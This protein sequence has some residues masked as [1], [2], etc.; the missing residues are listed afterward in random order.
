MMRAPI[1]VLALCLPLLAYAE[2]A[3]RKTSAADTAPPK[4]DFKLDLP[5]FDVPTTGDLE[6]GR[7]SQAQGKGPTKVAYAIEAVKHAKSFRVG[8]EGA[9]EP[10]G[11]IE[12]FKVPTFP[13]TV[14]AFETCLRLKASSGVVASIEARILDPQGKEVA[15][16]GGEVS[17]ARKSNTIDY[18]ISWIGFPARSGGQY[19]MVVRVGGETSR[20]LTLPVG[21]P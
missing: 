10:Q 8:R 4:M 17:F 18:V 9:C 12:S 15:S 5:S 3:T 19:K 14:E 21:A 20:E 13:A 6:D 11:A 2:T 1:A 7:T 16:A